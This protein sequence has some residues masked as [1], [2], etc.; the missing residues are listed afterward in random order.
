EGVHGAVHAQWAIGSGM[1]EQWLPSPMKLPQVV[2]GG[3]VRQI[4]SLDR[5]NGQRRQQAAF[6][7]QEL[8][9]D[10]P[11]APSYHAHRQQVSGIGQVL[12]LLPYRQPQIQQPHL[13]TITSLLRARSLAPGTLRKIGLLPESSTPGR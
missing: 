11:Q 13:L 3:L 12:Q 6:P 7:R 10:L 8:S 1:L 5:L 2:R 9:V 4:R